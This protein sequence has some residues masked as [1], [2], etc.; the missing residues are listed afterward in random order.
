MSHFNDPGAVNLVAGTFPCGSCNYCQNLD[1]LTSLTL[2]DGSTW[3]SRH[4]VDCNS[5]G[6]VY[7]LNCTCGDFYV[8]ITR[9]ELHR[10]IYDHV[11]AASICY[12]KSP[13]GRHMAFVQNC[14]PEPLTYVHLTLVPPD[15]RGCDWERILLQKEVRW[16]YHL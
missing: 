15:P 11:Y 12:Y 10:C 13:V 9:H 6:V 2:P 7:L 4:H 8:G 14:K 1:T 3:M 5:K 16:I